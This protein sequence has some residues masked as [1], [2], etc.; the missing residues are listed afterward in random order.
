L[1]DYRHAISGSAHTLPPAAA[2]GCRRQFLLAYFGQDLPHP[3]GH[4]DTC[5]S[6]SA[7]ELDYDS[8]DSPFPLDSRVAHAVFGKGVVL[9]FEGDRIIVLFDD[10]GYRTL[11]LRAVT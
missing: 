4:C 3:Y 10:V 9:R 1:Q 11:S 7:Y 2:A 5:E 6:R 8:A